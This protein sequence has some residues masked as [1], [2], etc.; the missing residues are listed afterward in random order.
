MFVRH[1]H[2]LVSAVLRN[3]Q[4]LARSAADDGGG[5]LQRGRR[6]HEVSLRLEVG[7]GDV[8]G[9]RTDYSRRLRKQDEMDRNPLLLI[10]F[11]FQVV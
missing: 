10:L 2:R 3:R 11:L 6:L 4:I 9:R 8:G 1:A 5:R 7:G